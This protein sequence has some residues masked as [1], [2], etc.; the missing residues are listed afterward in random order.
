MGEGDSA[1]HSSKHVVLLTLFLSG[2]LLVTSV[3]GP[4]HN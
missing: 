1:S 3:E 2:N 4:S